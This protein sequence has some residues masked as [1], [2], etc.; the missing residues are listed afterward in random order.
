[1]LPAIFDNWFRTT[2]P[3]TGKAKGYGAP[4]CPGNWQR[5]EEILSNQRKK[6]ERD[7]V[8]NLLSGKTR[9]ARTKKR[10]KGRAATTK[11]KKT[12]KKKKK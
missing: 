5:L 8:L 3:Y 12:K 4:A 11:R 10:S 9:N 7:A 1:M 6:S 2:S